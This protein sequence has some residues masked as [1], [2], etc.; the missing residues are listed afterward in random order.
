M[1]R[2]MVF[3]GGLHRSGTTLLQFLVG[4]HPDYAAVGEVYDLIQSGSE[5][6]RQAGEVQCSC[7]VS[8]ERCRFWGPLI[9]TLQHTAGGSETERYKLFLHRFEE[10]FGSGIVP[11]DSSKD[12]RALQHLAQIRGLQTKVLFS[13]RDVRA[14][15]VSVRE[16]A[17]RNRGQNSGP[18]RVRAFWRW[19]RGNIRY[20]EALGNTDL[21]WLLVSYEELV[22]RPEQSLERIMTFLGDSVRGDMLNF[23]Q[24]GHHAV[25]V[26]R[27]MGDRQKMTHLWYDN[28]WFCRTG[29]WTFPALLF[30]N[31]MRFN[32]EH[33]YG[34]VDNSF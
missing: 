32:R 15:T 23:D 13:I 31:I 20:M 30:P 5:S 16:R 17:G 18:G 24:A 27:M 10:F 34:Y 26:N 9:P 4:A 6:L 29:H 8:A 14:W 2:E 33:V 7:G 28:R 21:R 19:Y 3:V 22:L 11:V 25:L 1:A 12:L